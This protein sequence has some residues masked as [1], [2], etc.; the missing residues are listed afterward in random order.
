MKD[1][2]IY[3][4]H[5]LKSIK[6]ILEYTRDINKQGFSAST[7]V[8]N[9]VIRNF[10][11]IGEASK[12]V[13]EEFKKVNQ[14]FLGR[15]WPECVISLFMIILGWILMLFGKLLNRIFPA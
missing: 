8:Q 5:I 9:A 10:E 15:K 2:A 3:L 4:D 11:I 13:S 14:R 1:D 12:K 6:N 7:L